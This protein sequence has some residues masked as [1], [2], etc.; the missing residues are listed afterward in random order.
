MLTQLDKSLIKFSKKFD[1]LFARLAIFIVFFW[2]GILKVFG[3]SPANALVANLLEKTLPF[4]QFEQF[5]IFFGVVEMIIGISFIIPRFERLAIALLVLHM[6]TTALP[7]FFLPDITWQQF[8]VPSL[9]G[10]YIIKNVALIA[11]A[12]GIGSRLSINFK[13]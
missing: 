1:L 8:L 12:V 2:F 6:L 7:L 13:R 4:F 9:E 3:F 5:I 10:Q 11:L